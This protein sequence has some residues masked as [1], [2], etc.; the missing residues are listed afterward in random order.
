VLE[1]EFFVSPLACNQVRL[2]PDVSDHFKLVVLLGVVARE[3]WLILSVDL[4]DNISCL[5]SSALDLFNPMNLGSIFIKLLLISKITSE[6]FRRSEVD[7]VGYSHIFVIK[8]AAIVAHLSD[9][10]DSKAERS[11]IT[12]NQLLLESILHDVT[13]LCSVIEDK[14]SVSQDGV[15]KVP[16]SR[17]NE[18][19]H[20][21]DVIRLLAIDEEFQANRGSKTVAIFK[22]ICHLRETHDNGI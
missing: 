14:K 3:H 4:V 12:F 6:L 9:V 13:S 18:T 17:C 11:T 21:H 5:E 8:S 10:A 16:V 22:K 20:G 15:E 7:L 1:E 19:L 2:K